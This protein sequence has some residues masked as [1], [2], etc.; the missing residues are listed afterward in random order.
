MSSRKC[1]ACDEEISANAQ[2]C[3]YCKTLQDD[4]RFGTAG[5]EDLPPTRVKEKSIA[6]S[7]LAPTTPNEPKT[8][9]KSRTIRVIAFTLGAIAMVG[10]SAT[11][12]FWQ[13]SGGGTP[14][15]DPTI[16]TNT[17]STA[18]SDTSAQDRTALKEAFQLSAETA[19]RDGCVEQ[20]LMKWG[21]NNSEE[22]FSVIAYDPYNTTFYAEGMLAAT[23]SRSLEPSYVWTYSPDFQTAMEYSFFVILGKTEFSEIA[24]SDS[25]KLV[26]PNVYSIHFG[27]YAY[28]TWTIHVTQG[29]ITQ[30][31]A[32]DSS[33]GTWTI[34][35]QYSISEDGA[36]V[37]DNAEV[38]NSEFD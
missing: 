10:V 8:L 12:L 16:P 37:L 4:P 34:E 9:Q 17:E 7:P 30:A 27:D 36:K 20:S 24:D 6:K 11:F 26:E 35:T 14:A 18:V 1:I 25:F 3:K 31:E 19:L 38:V 23:G 29:L 28:D 13:N 21:D 33:G 32:I 15:A 5:S 2:L 22:T